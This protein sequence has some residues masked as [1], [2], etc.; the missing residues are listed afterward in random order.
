MGESER[1]ETGEAL[2]YVATAA[3]SATIS[4]AIG[5]LIGGAM[6]M[7][8]VTQLLHEVDTLKAEVRRL[9]REL[10]AVSYAGEPRRSGKMSVA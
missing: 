6:A 7:G 1:I 10:E 3:I 4:A 8:K 5:F 2:S 9:S